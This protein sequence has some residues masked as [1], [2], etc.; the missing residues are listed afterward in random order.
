[1]K[2]S[3]LSEYKSAVRLIV[4]ETSPSDIEEIKRFIEPHATADQNKSFQIF[5]NFDSLLREKHD[6]LAS[7][8]SKQSPVTT[9]AL[10]QIKDLYSKF[11]MLKDDQDDRWGYKS[12]A[13]YLP[14][15]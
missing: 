5:W 7:L 12:L 6:F 11:L 3:L 4:H 15:D 10:Q 2:K 8:P 13:K 1:M 9:E 14:K